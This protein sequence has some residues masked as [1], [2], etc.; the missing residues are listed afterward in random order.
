ML[1][2]YRDTQGKMNRRQEMCWQ[3]AAADDEKRTRSTIRFM[4]EEGK[5]VLISK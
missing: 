1:T 5:A 2:E 4:V 3:T